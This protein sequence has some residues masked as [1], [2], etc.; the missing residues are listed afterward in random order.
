MGNTCGWSNNCLTY[1][2][3]EPNEVLLFGDNDSLLENGSSR[4][5]KH[6]GAFNLDDSA[7]DITK[8]P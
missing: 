7:F 8:N 2:T 3:I 1:K 4:R 6:K 5:L